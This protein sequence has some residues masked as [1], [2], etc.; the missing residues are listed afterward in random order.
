MDPSLL[1]RAKPLPG[2]KHSTFIL[3]TSLAF[4]IFMT[5]DRKFWNWAFLE[6]S[7]V[8]NHK[9]LSFCAGLISLRQTFFQDLSM[10]QPILKSD[11][12]YGRIVSHEVY[13]LYLIHS[14]FDGL[15][16][17][18]YLGIV[19][20]TI[21]NTGVWY[22]TGKMRNCDWTCEIHRVSQHKVWIL[23]ECMDF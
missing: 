19:N 20:N 17:F 11:Y 12:F 5:L 15:Q 3:L 23:M 10:W 21:M 2:I 7:Y 9:L 22:T 16:G 14:S 8:W 4:S 18:F 13:T 6:T 1:S